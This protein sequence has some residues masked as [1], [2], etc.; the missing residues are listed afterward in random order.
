MRNRSRPG[1]SPGATSSTKRGT[2]A[3][4]VSTWAS[5]A[6]FKIYLGQFLVLAGLM[7]RPYPRHFTE[8]ALVL[9][10]RS[11][12]PQHWQQPAPPYEMLEAW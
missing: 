6:D 5:P 2:P 1:A 10:C 3:S 12:I 4:L 9:R 8:P 11:R 7:G